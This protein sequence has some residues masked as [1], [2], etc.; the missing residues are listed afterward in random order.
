MRDRRSWKPTPD[1]RTRGRAQGQADT[2]GEHLERGVGGLVLRVDQEDLLLGPDAADARLDPSPFEHGLERA[3]V[4]E[5]RL[6]EAAHL[7]V[8]ELLLDPV[9]SHGEPF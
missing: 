9:L 7:D 1:D 2:L 8:V 4:L 6:D 3:D 5:Q